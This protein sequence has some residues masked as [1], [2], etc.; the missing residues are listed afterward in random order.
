MPAPGVYIVTQY[1]NPQNK[2]IWTL[3]SDGSITDAGPI[4]SGGNSTAGQ[5]NGIS[6]AVVYPGGGGGFSQFDIAPTTF[7]ATAPGNSNAGLSVGIPVSNVS[8]GE[9][10]YGIVSDILVLT[11]DTNAH[12]AVWGIWAQADHQGSGIITYL[13][14][15]FNAYNDSTGTVTNLVAALIQTYNTGT[16]T[17]TN[18]I[19]VS[20]QVGSQHGT[21]THSYGIQILSPITGGT[22]TNPP[23]GLLI[24]DQTI[25]GAQPNAY[26]IQSLGGR[27]RL[28]GLHIYVNNAAA[29]TGGLAVGDLYRTGAD[30]DVVCVVH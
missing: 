27:V 22:F 5:I 4:G 21:V 20:I 13:G 14:N 11:G 19:G 26:A 25:S 3:Y 24:N 1:L 18:N 7:P 15:T 6:Y 9:Y 17:T 23:I 28:T 30:P 8:S 16:G 10:T 29:V 12:N 2:A